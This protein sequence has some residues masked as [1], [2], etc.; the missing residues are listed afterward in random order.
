MSTR[1]GGFRLVLAMMLLWGIAAAPLSATQFGGGK[2]LSMVQFPTILE[3]GSLN[4]TFHTRAFVKNLPGVAYSLSDGTGAIS[5]NFGFSKHVE[6]GFTQILYQDLNISAH[7]NGF[8][9]LEQIPDDSYLRIKVGGYPLTL[10]DAYFKLG[11]L[12]QLR[13]RTGI[14]S[15]IYLEPY[16]GNGI[17]WESDLL[18]SYYTNP[19]YEEYGPTFHANLGYVNYNDGEIGTSYFKSAQSFV[20]GLAFVYPLKRFD[21]GLETSGNLFV[22]APEA[23][24]YS[25]ESCQWITPSFRWKMFYGMSTM[26][27][28][29]LLLWEGEDKTDYSLPDVQALPLGGPNYPSWRLNG[30][31]SISPSTAFF[32]QPTFSAVMDPQTARQMLANRRSL[33][34]WVVDDQQGLEYLDVELEK[35]KAERKKA[36]QQ[37]EELKSELEGQ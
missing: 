33:F 29:D 7:D 20:Y 9:A 4:I 21:L 11:W 14:V 25:R 10:G 31:I 17:E 22:R 13:Y 15:N 5:F 34:E 32:K 19:L 8:K 30:A 23:F 2:G 26:L 24:A 1:T 18:L 37:L 28:L 6:L 16:S 12:N 35:I 36:E 27:S 3:T